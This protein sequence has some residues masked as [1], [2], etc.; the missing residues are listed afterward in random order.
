MSEYGEKI[1]AETLRIERLLPGPIE[2]LWQYLVDSDRRREWL[3]A[4][5]L[6]ES[7]GAPLELVFR[8]NDL[9]QS[10]DRAPEKYAH[11]GD[12]ARLHCHIIDCEAPRQL[13]LAWGTPMERHRRCASSWRRK[14]I[15]YCW[16]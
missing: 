4:G 11:I 3:A 15:R 13:T 14:G 5:E 12:E 1:A 8:N 16:W 6:V 7:G 10:D 2:R 9:S